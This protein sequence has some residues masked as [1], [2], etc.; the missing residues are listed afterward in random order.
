[1]TRLKFTSPRRR[2]RSWK[3]L[4]DPVSGEATWPPP[5]PSVAAA[6]AMSMGGSFDRR[7]NEARWHEVLSERTAQQAREHNNVAEYN[8]SREAGREAKANEQGGS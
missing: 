7:Y 4:I 1:V 2:R 6:C 8:Q 5:Q 3:R